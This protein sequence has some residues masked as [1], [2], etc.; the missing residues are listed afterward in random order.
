MVAASEALLA[1]DRADSVE[2]AAESRVRIQ[3]VVYELH[4]HGLHRRDREDRLANAGAQTAQKTIAG[5]QGAIRI[6]SHVFELLERTESNGRLRYGA[7]DEHRQTTIQAGHTMTLHGLLN[8]VGDAWFGNG[9][10]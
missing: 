10:T 7:V 6:L 4:L 5:R 3:L 8:A 1:N 9:E 2:E